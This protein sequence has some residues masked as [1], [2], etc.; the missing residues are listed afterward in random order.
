MIIARVKIF[1]EVTAPLGSNA[2]ACRFESCHPHQEITNPFRGWLFLYARWVDSNPS[3]ASVRWTLAAASANTGCYLTNIPSPARDIRPSSPDINTHQNPTTHRTNG[4][5]V[6]TL[7]ASL[8]ACHRQAMQ[9]S[10]VIRTGQQKQPPVPK[11]RG[12]QSILSLRGKY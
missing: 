9:S 3:N 11:N 6:Q 1:T 8:T 4:P 12:L 5:P 2:Q 10:P 7:A